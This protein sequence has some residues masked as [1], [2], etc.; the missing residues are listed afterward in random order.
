MG[1][2]VTETSLLG[3]RYTL[4]EDGSEEVADSAFEWALDPRA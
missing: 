4:G 3:S 2:V 1:A